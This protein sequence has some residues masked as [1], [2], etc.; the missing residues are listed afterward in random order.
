[1]S[2]EQ[3]DFKLRMRARQ[4]AQKEPA[5]QEQ[6][7]AEA[8]A[9]KKNRDLLLALDI[10]AVLLACTQ[11]PRKRVMSSRARHK[12]DVWSHMGDAIFGRLD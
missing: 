2:K 11:K 9:K 1:M 10:A 4:E 12:K 7:A 5:R 8:A 3:P 6:I